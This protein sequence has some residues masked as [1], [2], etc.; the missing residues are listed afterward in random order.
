MTTVRRVVTTDTEEEVFR[1]VRLPDVLFYW[2]RSHT[3]N[4]CDPDH[5]AFDCFTFGFG[6]EQ[7][8]LAA[9]ARNL[10]AQYATE[11]LRLERRSEQSPPSVTGTEMGTP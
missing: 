10:I 3:V 1:D 8:D 6:S 7:K 9:Q 2:N 11:Y 4:V 5:A